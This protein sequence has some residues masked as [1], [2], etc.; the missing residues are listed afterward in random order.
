MKAIILAAGRGSRMGAFTKDK[1]KCLLK[2]E[3][4]RLIDWQIEALINCGLKDIGIVTGYRRAD[5]QEF[6]LKEFYNSRWNQTNMVGSLLQAKEWL[7]KSSCI[8]TYS[9]IFYMSSAIDILKKSKSDIAIT[10]DPDWLNLWKSRFSDPLSDAETFKLNSNGMLTEIG[11]KPQN[12][13]EVEGQ[14]MGLLKFSPE[15]W[16]TCE[17]II[18]S[19]SFQERDIIHMTSLLDK[20]SKNNL[21]G[22]AALP[23]KEKWGEVDFESDFQ[24]YNNSNH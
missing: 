21:Y 8:V 19:L 17:Q 13:N 3:G 10:Y 15:G 6:G 16:K 14:Y 9:D 5:L 4:K 20:V 24:F 22:V 7:S 12:I 2:V 11:K 1:H 18:S 23:Y